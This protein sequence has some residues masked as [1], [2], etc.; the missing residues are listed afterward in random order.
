MGKK[1]KNTIIRNAV[2]MCTAAVM[3]TG[4]GFTSFAF[5]KADMNQ[6]ELAARGETK[7]E[8]D[9]YSASFT[10]G[11]EDTVAKVPEKSIAAVVPKVHVKADENVED[12]VLKERIPAYSLS[13]IVSM[14]MT[15]ASGVTEDDLKA[16]GTHSGLKGLESAFVKAEKDYG[17]NCLFLYGIAVTESSGGTAM[18]KPNNM[19]GYGHKSFSSKAECIDYVAQR[20]SEDYLSETGPYYRGKTPTDVNKVYCTGDTWHGKV[21]KTMY[22]MYQDIRQNNLARYD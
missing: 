2:L 18:F 1:R 22:T 19:F 20:I 4:L 10:E 12:N 11:V 9:K 17:V 3:I 8:A 13:D 15:A 16:A 7:T 5:A 21:E 14:D 6:L